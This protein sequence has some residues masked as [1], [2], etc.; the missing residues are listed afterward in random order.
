[1][2]EMSPPHMLSQKN[3]LFTISHAVGHGSASL[4]NENDYRA[5]SLEEIKRESGKQEIDLVNSLD[6]ANK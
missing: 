6:G 5:N 2:H 1:M 4:P 3:Q